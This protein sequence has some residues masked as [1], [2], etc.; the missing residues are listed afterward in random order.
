MWYNYKFLTVL[1]IQKSKWAYSKDN[2]WGFLKKINVIQWVLY[3]D[4]TW[5]FL[6]VSFRELYIFIANML[7]KKKYEIW[8]QNQM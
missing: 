5:A 4:V 3:V 8:I 2:K 6:T 7:N 1:A